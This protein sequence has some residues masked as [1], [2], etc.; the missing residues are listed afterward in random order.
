MGYMSPQILAKKKFDPFKAD[1]WALGILT[2]KMLFNLFPYKGKSEDEIYRKIKGSKLN[3]PSTIKA[4]KSIKNFIS[5]L[6]NKK[7]KER[8]N[9]QE[10]FLKFEET[11]KNK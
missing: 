9:I 5:F 2:Y 11:F 1:I 6:L 4:S 3:F 10:V 8:P 7:E